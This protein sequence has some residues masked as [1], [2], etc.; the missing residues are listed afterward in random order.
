MSTTNTKHFYASRWIV[1]L[2]LLGFGD[3]EDLICMM[4]HE[5]YSA[6]IE[7]LKLST[8]LYIPENMSTVSKTS[9]IRCRA[10]K[11]DDKTRCENFHKN[12][13]TLVCNR[14][15]NKPAYQWNGNNLISR[16][17]PPQLVASKTLSASSDQPIVKKTP[18]SPQKK[19]QTVLRK[20]KNGMIYWPGTN[21]VVRSFEEPKVYCREIR[22]DVYEPLTE[23]DITYC[24]Q[25]RIPYIVLDLFNY[26]GEPEPPSSYLIEEL[27]SVETDPI[28]HLN[29]D[30]FGDSPDYDEYTDPF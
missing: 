20:C 27:K 10:T 23:A 2:C 12:H 29:P 19:Q 5:C 1:Q 16:D 17:P 8:D 15:A 7:D 4:E 14:H 9:S 24:K 22:K 18:V 30:E 25:F 21:F 13:E 11:A 26:N 28:R 6:Q 3:L